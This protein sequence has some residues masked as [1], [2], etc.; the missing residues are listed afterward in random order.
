MFTTRRPV[1]G[2]L[3]SV[4]VSPQIVIDFQFN[5]TN[6]AD[7]RTANYAPLAAPGAL[8]PSRQYTSGGDRTL[9][10]TVTIDGMSV[11]RLDGPRIDVDEDGGIG[12]EL[13]KYRALAY[14]RTPDWQNAAYLSDGF[15]GLYAG[16]EP[17]IFTSPPQVMFGFGDQVIDCLVTEI[18]IT[19][20]LFTPTL[21]PLR[22]EVAVTL[23]ELNPYQL[24]VDGT[25][26]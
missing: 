1:R 16:Q 14:P 10:F 5:P 20:T 24:N 7:K 23:S 15:T 9:T 12:P 3:I 8:L 26:L 13:T 11:D 2:C 25:M 17:A 6:L 19:E 18:S 4:G 21:A 22:A